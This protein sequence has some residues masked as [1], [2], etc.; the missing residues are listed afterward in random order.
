MS[1]IGAYA[2]NSKTILPASG[3]E[4]RFRRVLRMPLSIFAGL[5]QENRTHAAIC[6]FGESELLG[7]PVENP[8]VVLDQLGKAGLEI[9][10][11]APSIDVMVDRLA[12]G[13]RN[14]HAIGAS[15]RLEFSGFV[16]WETHRE[17]F[18]HR[19]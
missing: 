9:L 7:E 17:S 8:L 16:L 11:L 2:P 10:V 15:D 4:L 3:P 13:L 1:A 6:A 19:P 18:G 12:Y 14:G 5:W